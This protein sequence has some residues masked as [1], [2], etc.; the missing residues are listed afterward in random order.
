VTKALV[1]EYDLCVFDLDGVVYVGPEPVPGAVPAITRLHERGV[2]VAYATNN[3]SRRAR[4]VAA[5][6]TGLGVA[7]TA[8]EVVTSAQATA[9]LLGQRLPPASRVLVVGAEALAAELSAAGLTPV[10]GAAENPVAVVQGYGPD[11]GWR[12]LAEGCVAVLGGA[13]WVATNDDKT[14]PSPRGPLPGNGALVAALATAVDREPDL[15]VG[16]PAPALFEQAARR[17]GAN[18]PLVVGD[19]LDTDIEGANRA[20]MDSVLVLTGVARPVDALGA[21][22]ARR[23][24]YIAEDLGGLFEPADEVRVDT[25]WAGW[26]AYPDSGGEL[27]LSGAG[28][29]VAALRALCAAAWR[30]ADGDPERMRVRAEGEQAAQALTELGIARATASSGA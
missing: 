29:A 13:L 4:E 19:R 26:R 7:A 25:G 3:A 8:Q 10:V 6:L 20:G 16:K 12:Q 27:V 15:V 17:R 22:P 1:D 9:Q 14:L 24:V 30:A 5:L 21:P 11:V 28:P 18:R 2:G 23:P